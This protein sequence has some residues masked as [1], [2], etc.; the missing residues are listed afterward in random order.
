MTIRSCSH[1]RSALR[2]RSIAHVLQQQ[3]RS[4]TTTAQRLELHGDGRGVPPRDESNAVCARDSTAARQQRYEE[5][6][7][8]T[9]NGRLGPG[10]ETVRAGAQRL[11][12]L[13]RPMR[14]ASQPV[15]Q[16]ARASEVVGRTSRQVGAAILPVHRSFCNLCKIH[17]R[18]NTHAKM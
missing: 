3:A 13:R 15:C 10:D 6:S 9:P 8:A 5:V 17:C 1:H 2:M 14:V 7:Q 4:I 11:S 12:E 16:Q 18:L